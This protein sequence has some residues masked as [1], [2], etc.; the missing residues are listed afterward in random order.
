MLQEIANWGIAP[1]WHAARGK[2]MPRTECSSASSSYDAN[3]SWRS[4][5]EIWE[6]NNGQTGLSNAVVS[7]PLPTPPRNLDFRSLISRFAF[8]AE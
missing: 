7:R 1:P 4:G 6:R 8:A 3:E 5:P 2:A